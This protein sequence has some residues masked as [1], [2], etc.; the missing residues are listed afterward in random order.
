MSPEHVTQQRVTGAADVWAAGVN[1]YQLLTNRSPFQRD[2]FAQTMD[3]VVNWTQPP[4]HSVDR[5]A[6]VE[7]SKIAD[8]ALMKPVAE[9][10]SGAGAMHDDLEAWLAGQKAGAAELS[11]FVESLFPADENTDRVRLAKVL[12]APVPTE[13]KSVEVSLSGLTPNLAAVTAKTDAPGA[14]STQS[15]QEFA[16]QPTIM[17]G[18]GGNEP[19]RPFRTGGMLTLLRD[20][21]VAITA[22]ALLLSL[23]LVV[24]IAWN[25]S[26]AKPAVAA[27]PPPV[28]HVAAP[29]PPEPEPD[30]AA[31]PEPAAATGTLVVHS[32]APGSFSVAGHLL[33]PN[34]P[35]TL[36]QG[37][38]EVILVQKKRFTRRQTAVVKP[39]ETT[40]VTF[41]RR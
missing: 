7:L 37:T 35:L 4:A 14:S 5:A 11:E 17:V 23:V 33:A 10:Y 18:R 19:T 28:E 31:Q 9:R 2:A 8:R 20:P 24:G 38:Y 1:L 13:P 22:G 26:R 21:P 29:P 12:S 34:T 32:A 15:T 36:P 40:V 6:P 25:L 39:G 30:A 41:E 27:Q 16:D 3:A